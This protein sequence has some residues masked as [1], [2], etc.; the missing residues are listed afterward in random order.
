MTRISTN[1]LGFLPDGIPKP[2]VVDMGHSVVFFGP[3]RGDGKVLSLGLSK[4]EMEDEQQSLN[5][6]FVAAKRYADEYVAEFG[7]P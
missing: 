7:K 5:R 1:F 4:E 6:A 3:K 2:K